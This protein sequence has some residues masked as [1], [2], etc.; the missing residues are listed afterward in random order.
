MRINVTNNLK[1]ERMAAELAR[2][3]ARGPGCAGSD[4]VK[5]N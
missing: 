1:A 4:T 2:R 3:S 5:V